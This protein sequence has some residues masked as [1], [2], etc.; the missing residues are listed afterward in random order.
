MALVKIIPLNELGDIISEPCVEL[1]NFRVII[2]I[3]SSFLF[4]E[5]YKNGGSKFISMAL[6]KI[7]PLNELGDIISA[8]C[9]EL[10]SFRVVISNT[11]NQINF[12]F[13]F[14]GL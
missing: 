4:R 6:A 8:P 12:S 1:N 11:V 7:I 10:N 2:Q 9:V 14:R 13:L 5:L 3:V